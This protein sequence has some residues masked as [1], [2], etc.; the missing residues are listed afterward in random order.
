MRFGEQLKEMVL[1]G[2]S[3]AE[4]KA[5]AIRSGMRPCACSGIEKIIA[6]RDDHRGSRPR[7]HR[8]D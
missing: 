8:D 3:T 2:A 5:A 1:Q 6:G 7:H 4:L